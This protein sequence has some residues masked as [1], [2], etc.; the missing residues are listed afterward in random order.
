MDKISKERANLFASTCGGIARLT[1]VSLVLVAASAAQSEAAR[2]EGKCEWFFLRPFYRRQVECKEIPRL[3]KINELGLKCKKGKHSA[4]EE[5]AKVAVHNESTIERME[6]VEEVNDRDLLSKIATEDP[7]GAVR[8]IAVEGLDSKGSESQSLL[9]RIATEDSDPAVRIAA[10]EELPEQSLLAKIAVA[11]KEAGVRFAAVTR[12]FRHPQAFGALLKENPG[13]ASI[14]AKGGRTLLHVA[15]QRGDLDI[16]KLLLN[17]NVDA[18]V[19]D[20]EGC[21]PLH[22]LAGRG[23]L[24]DTLNS[25]DYVDLLVTHGADVNARNKKG[26]TP[27]FLAVG[28]VTSNV[29]LLVYG[30]G[31]PASYPPFVLAQSLLDHGAD[32]NAKDNQNITPLR[33]ALLARGGTEPTATDSY[34]I[35]RM[36]YLL[37][38]SVI[39]LLR[40][41]GGHE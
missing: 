20:D 31:Q 16:V 13:V 14:R 5:L 8:Q 2:P 3:K 41:R 24:V 35:P 6:A 36:Q 12:L 9:A 28:A 34:G 25:K 7:N 11:D 1:V 27:L 23:V 38:R 37:E 21:T 26:E 4:C 18:N 15:V 40:Q 32:V 30:A 10:V 22:D 29:A 19:T 17:S 33:H 39:D